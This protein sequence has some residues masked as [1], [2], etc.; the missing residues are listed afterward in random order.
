MNETY[1]ANLENLEKKY[2]GKIRKNINKSENKKDL[3]KIFSFTVSDFLNHV[4]DEEIKI[5]ETDISFSPVQKNRYIFSP[6]LLESEYFI[7]KWNN[8]NLPGFINKVADT[9]YHRYLHLNK[10]IEKT[11]KKIRQSDSRNIKAF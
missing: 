6:R 2:L 8:S 5:S 3:E 11:E 4:L 1:F 10:H 9:T 7:Q